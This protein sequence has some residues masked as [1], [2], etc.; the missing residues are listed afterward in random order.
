VSD[1]EHI[2]GLCAS[3]QAAEAG[4]AVRENWLTLGRMLATAAPDAH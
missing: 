2:I 4:S 3:G 1:H